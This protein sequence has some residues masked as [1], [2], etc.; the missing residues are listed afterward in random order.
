MR[1]ETRGSGKKGRGDKRR[2]DNGKMRK[3]REK[4]GRDIWKQ[5]TELDKSK[6]R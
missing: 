6:R 3:R 2:K 1:G 5:M 4:E